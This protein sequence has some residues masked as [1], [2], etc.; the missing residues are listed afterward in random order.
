MI[1]LALPARASA[2]R[3]AVYGSRVELA[4]VQYVVACCGSPG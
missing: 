3:T 4:K 1:L 2:G